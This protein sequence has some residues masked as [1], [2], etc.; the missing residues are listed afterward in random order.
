M[1]FCLHLQ[2]RYFQQ[3]HY[4]YMLDIAIIGGGAAGFF[5]AITA[6]R[7]LPEARVTVFERAKKVLAKVEVSGGGRCNL[8][9]SFAD[10]TDLKQV[11]PRGFRLMKR[12]FK[13]FDYVSTYQ[14]FEDN[15]VALT[16]QEDQCVFPRSQDSH[17]VT[18]C[19]TAQARQLGVEIR[20]QHTLTA[21]KKLGNGDFELH[22]KEQQP[23]VFNR[24]AITT[25]GSPRLSSVQY[26]A[27]MGHEIAMPVPSLFTFNV[28]D[29]ALRNLMGTVVEHAAVSIPSTKMRTAGELLITHW[30]MSGPA[31]LKLS[32][33]AARIISERGYRFPLSVNWIGR[34]NM[35]E[36]EEYLQETAVR[37]AQKQL[38]SIRPF[39][40]PSRLWL[41][42]L[43]R[44]AIASDKRWG[45]LGKKDNHRLMEALTNDVYE[46]TGKGSFR[47][48]FVTCG[49]I[50]LSN[51][52]MNTLESKHCAHLFF[53]GEILDIDGITGGFNLQAAWTTGYVVGQ[54]IVV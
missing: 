46:V 49:G 22:F 28:T 45:E 37:N 47:D 43:A 44:T 53:A 16:T 36:I 3:I 17:S 8:T 50:S 19:L 52:D 15:G 54:N 10:V 4:S 51:I 21:L 2:E 38:S 42:L 30:G 14:W 6:K 35:N 25:G 26:L 48:E 9:N 27:D 12:L 31:I 33:Y 20:I 7:R 18:D 39:G 41:H 29:K 5:A 23:L 24:I 32:S 11:Y 13:T 34:Y 1:A 40:I